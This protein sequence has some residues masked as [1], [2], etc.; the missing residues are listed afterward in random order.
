MD[1]KMNEKNLDVKKLL[2][3][4]NEILRDLLIH[5]AHLIEGETMPPSFVQFFTS[6]IV[7]DFYAASTDAGMVP[8]H[9]EGQT[10]VK[11]PK[12]FDEHII[13]TTEQLKAR[14]DSL[15]AKYAERL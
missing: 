1:K 15:H 3:K 9:L 12:A 4:Y 7:W 6:T 2:S 5:K 11:Y 13:T 14:I 8:K 10:L